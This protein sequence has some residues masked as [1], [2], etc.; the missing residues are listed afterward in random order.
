MNLMVP[1]ITK[2]LGRIYLVLPFL[3]IL[4][5]GETINRY[6]QDGG[7]ID[8]GT[9]V[10]ILILNRLCGF[11]TPLYAIA[12]WAEKYGIDE[13]YAIEAKRLTDDR[14]GNVLDKIFEHLNTLD[15]Q[16]TINLLKAFNIDVKQVHFD[17]SSFAV[18]GQQ[19]ARS[20]DPPSLH[21]TYGRDGKG[22][23]NQ[24]QVRFGLATANCGNMPLLGKAYS[25]NTSDNEMHPEFFDELLKILAGSDFLFVSDSRF[26]SEDNFINIF[27]HNGTF[28][29]P[30]VFREHVQKQFITLSEN[31]ETKWEKID[32]VA[33]ADKK[34]AKG[35]RPFYKAFETTEEIKIEINGEKITYSYRMVFVYSSEKAKLQQK[36]RNKRIRKIRSELKKIQFRLNTRDYIS[37]DYIE[38]KIAK[39]LNLNEMGKVFWYR[40]TEQ[41]GFFFLS[42]GVIGRKIERLKKLDGIYTLKTNLDDTHS[43]N[44]VFHIYKQ[45]SQIEHRMKVIKGPLQVAPIYLKDPKRIASLFFIIVQALKVYSIIEQETRKAIKEYG[46]P[47]PVLPE[48]RKTFSPTGETIL[49]VFDSSVSILIYSDFKGNKIRKL[50]KP[51]DIQKLIFCLLYMKLPDLRNLSRKFGKFRNR[52]APAR[53]LAFV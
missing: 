44:E 3:K 33:K 24:R 4:K 46:E 48:G 31:E 25:G 7:N 47:I 35:I 9:V 10:E 53:V 51:N 42:Y 28:L 50:T 17:A 15:S 37:R 21:V 30:G 11:R 39:A 32:Y 29:C 19:A 12:G 26:D 20:G 6:I 1:N 14:I 45:Q 18:T 16:V 22:R 8:I 43:I 36:T 2:N 52:G 5:I 34:K 49:R 27:Q 38:K 13:I 23:T 41:N 40:I